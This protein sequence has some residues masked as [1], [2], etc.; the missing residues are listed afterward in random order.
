ME[1]MVIWEQYTVTLN[2]DSR[3]GFGIAISGGRDRPSGADRDTSIIISDVVPGGPADGRL[4]TRDKIAM[5]NGLSME[6]VSSSFAI[7]TLKSC[8]KL[9]NITVK[10]PRKVHLPV[11]KSSQPKSPPLSSPALRDGRNDDSDGEYGYRGGGS[12]SPSG[13]ASYGQRRAEADHNRGYDGDSSSERSSGRY[14]D[15]EDAPRRH[16]V[17]NRRRSQDGGHRRRSQDSGSDRQRFTNGYSHRGNASGLALMSGFK[18]LP[19]QDFLLKPVR[20]I[21]VKNKESEEYGLKLGSQIFIKH[22]TD[23]GLAAKD[24][25]LQEGDLILKINGVA[26]ENLSLDETRQLIEQSEGRLTLVVLR[27][28][29]QFLVNIPQVRESESESSHLDDISDLAS[30]ISSPPPPAGSVPNSPKS[31]QSNSLPTRRRSSREQMSAE[32]LTPPVVH[33]TSESPEN[34]YNPPSDPFLSQSGGNY[35]YSPDSKTVHFIKAKNVGLRLAG[36]NDVGIF[37][38]GVQEGSPAE[39]QGIQEGDQI[40]QVNERVLHNLTREEAVRYLLELS[41]GEE[42]TLRVQNKQD[43]YRKMVKSNMGDSFYV[44]VHFDFEKDAPS[45]LSFT[46]GEVFHVVDT[47]Y[48]GKVGSW[49]ALRMGKELQELDK[50]IIPNSSRAEQIASLETVLKA[51]S[52]ASSGAR[53][54]FWKLRGLRGTKRNLRKSREDLSALTKQGH[55][56]PYEKVM[57]KEA[58]FKR[59]VVILGP[60]AD[61][62]MEKLSTEM[63]DQF[64]I[65]ESVVREGGSAKVIKLDSVWQIAKQDKHALLDITPEA[66]ER[67]NYVQYFPIVVFCEPDSRQGVK[68]MR[69]WLAPDSKKSSR[70]LFAQATKMRK[71][72]SHIFTATI[73]LAGGS[74]SWYQNVKD[75]V[76]IQ[77]ACPIWMTEEQVDASAEESLDLL[78]QPSPTTPGYLTCDSRAN[79]DYEETDAEGEPYMDQDIEES[80]QEPALARSSEPTEENP[81]QDLNERVAAAL[82]YPVESHDGDQQPQGQWRHNYIREYEHE[83]LRKKFTYA[84]TYDSESDQDYGYDWGPATDL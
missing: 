41:P 26:G 37:V 49:L 32:E 15:E 64:E 82:A 12:F 40:L 84:Q 77:Q 35:S 10:R 38:S 75:I 1:E 18:R 9:A 3:R 61:I 67:L 31:P 74:N 20:S 53:A 45:G 36:G 29:S 39:I 71:N 7:Q 17:R 55:Y 46:R 79:S 33:E 54:E 65:A 42:V 70:R 23:T 62:A 73:S 58:T 5:V 14:R 44:R 27:D 59:P 24:S 16:P 4:Q 48:R 30:D 43:I 34:A 57:L 13:R 8:G 11:T 80:Y 22:I 72:W 6:N 68:A 25:S 76:R 2:R 28:N 69:Q 60:I 66:V 47:L 51:T 21:L 19:Q 63:P 78:N 52:A 83:A 50:G 81:E 56:P